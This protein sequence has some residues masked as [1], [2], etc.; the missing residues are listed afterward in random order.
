MKSGEKTDALLN[1]NTVDE[2]ML[3]ELDGTYR[4]MANPQAVDTVFIQN[5][6]FVFVDGVF[7]ELILSDKVPF[8][9][10][11]KNRFAPVAS[12]TAYGMKSQTQGPTNVSTVRGGASQFRVLEMP[13]NLEIS[14]ASVNWIKIKNEMQKFTSER[15]L[16]KLLPE[17]EIDLKDYLK[18]NKLNL[19][20]KEDVFRI[21]LFCNQKLK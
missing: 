17:I 4:I 7:Y 19:R 11:N 12:N 3:V 21:G 6:K 13:E 2:E 15:Q 5:R 10:Q 18:K 14:Y 9:I 1:Y 8:Y 16:L 20:K